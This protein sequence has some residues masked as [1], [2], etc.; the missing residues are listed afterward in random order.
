MG[1]ADAAPEAVAAALADLGAPELPVT[2]LTQAIF[3]LSPEDEVAR[4]VA[5]TSDRR[6]GFYRWWL[7][8]RAEPGEEA[9]T[10]AALLPPPA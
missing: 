6:D 2:A 1:D 8:L 3:G 10:L 9:A 7:F 4:G 5:I